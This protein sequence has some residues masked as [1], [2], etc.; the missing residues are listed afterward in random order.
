MSLTKLTCILGKVSSPT[1][2]VVVDVAKIHGNSSKWIFDIEHKLS[3]ADL[4]KEGPVEPVLLRVQLLDFR[5]SKPK[6]KGLLSPHASPLN[7]FAAQTCIFFPEPDDLVIVI[8]TLG[9]LLTDAAGVSVAEVEPVAAP[10]SALPTPTLRYRVTV[11]AL[12]SMH[13]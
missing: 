3:E 6:P 1:A 4:D 12:H 9:K 5:S 10:A 13:R 11:D 8:Q 2:G 7:I